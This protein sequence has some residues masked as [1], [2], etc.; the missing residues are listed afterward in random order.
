[1][2]GQDWGRMGTP[3]LQEWDG[4]G[5]RHGVEKGGREMAELGWGRKETGLGQDG[6]RGAVGL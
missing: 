5:Q 3:E 4:E 2:L 6:K 1:M